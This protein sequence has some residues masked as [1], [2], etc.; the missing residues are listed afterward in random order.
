MSERRRVV[1]TGM[2]V[3]TPLGL[4]L[5][6]TWE[7]AK[8]GKSGITRITQFDPSPMPTQIAG[9]LKGFKPEAYMP[10]REAR[11]MA[12]C[13]QIA[14]AAT[15]QALADAGITLPLANPE[16][17]GVSVGVGMGGMEW[18][19]NQARNYWEKGLSSVSPF[20]ITASLPNIPAYHVSV[21][22]GAQ[23]AF[24]APVA[25]CASGAQ[26]IG[27]AAEFIRNGRAD[28]MLAGGTEALVYDIAIGAFCAMRAMS[29]R[30]DEPE[31]ASRPFDR[32]RDG[33]VFAEGAGMVVLES[34]EHAQARGARIYAEVLGHASSLD[35]YHIAQ[36]DPEG[37]GAQRAMR[38]A[39]QDA[40]IAPEEVD[41]INTHGTGTSLG[42]P[43]ETFAV[44]SVFGKH[45]YKLALSSTKSMMGHTMGAAGAVEAIIT[46]MTLV[47]G[48]ITPTINLDNPDPQCDLDYT[49]NV[50]RKADVRIAMKNAFGLGGQNSCL[51]LKRWEE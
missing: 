11:R 12:R 24:I 49:P 30:N 48:I 39:L 28:V 42:D 34:L 35:A 7:N 15:Q 5:A 20:A 43:I 18:T 13:S 41:Y 17:V 3:L 4:T 45:A 38:W 25:A 19:C 26:A 22:T 16:R 10:A 23:G 33:F 21:Y 44:K 50:A 47:E 29:T 8:A 9:E 32:D 36:P 37:R 51:I 2:G 6:E 14:L 31:R 27:E 40:G 46:V 1:I